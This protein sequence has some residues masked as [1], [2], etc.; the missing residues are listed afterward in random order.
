MQTSAFVTYMGERLNADLTRENILDMINKAQNEI[1]S[2]D[3]RLVQIIPD[4]AVHTGSEIFNG[5][6]GNNSGNDTFQVSQNVTANFPDTPTRG[7][8]LVTDAAGLITKLP[9]QS[10]TAGVFQLED[11]EFLPQNY[12]T[13]AT[14]QV[15]QFDIVASG[16]LFTSTR[17]DPRRIQYDVRRVSRVYGFTNSV[18]GY[19]FYNYYYGVFGTSGQA[20][21]RRPDEQ[22]NINNPEIKISCDTIESLEPLSGDAK[23]IIWEDNTPPSNPANSLYIARAYRWPDQ[24]VNEQV[25]LTVPSRFQTTLLKFAIFK[26]EEYREWGANDKPELLYEKYLKDFLSW[27]EGGAQTTKRTYTSPRF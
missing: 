23:I 12:T 10:Y 27:A 19:N 15:D 22:A 17:N 4:P 8:L 16:A 6:V 25:A 20:A 1:M 14:A 13:A 26:D 2:N 7:F 3:N 5:I 24:L 18:P 11:G 21:S 9:Y